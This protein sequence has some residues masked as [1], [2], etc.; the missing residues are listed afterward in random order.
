MKYKDMSVLITGISGFVGPYLAEDLLKKRARV[1]FNKEK[2]GWP[3]T[4]KSGR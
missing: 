4:K 2:V 1:W 3:Y